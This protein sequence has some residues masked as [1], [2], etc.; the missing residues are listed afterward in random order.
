THFVEVG[1]GSWAAP[2]D[3]SLECGDAVPILRGGSPFS[4][5]QIRFVSSCSTSHGKAMTVTWLP[6][7]EIEEPPQKRRNIPSRRTDRG[8]MGSACF[9]AA[10]PGRPIDRRWQAQARGAEA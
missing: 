3:T 8:S 6:S 4:R 2:M 10:T 1:R 5:F 9:R 7:V